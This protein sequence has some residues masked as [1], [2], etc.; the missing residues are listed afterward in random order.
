[1]SKEGYK[2]FICGSEITEANKTDEH[3]ILNAIG[4]A[5]TFV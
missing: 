1:M 2:C 3:I 4:G 5:S